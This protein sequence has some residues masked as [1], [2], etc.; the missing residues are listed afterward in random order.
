MYYLL[1]DRIVLDYIG[2]YWIGLYRI[3]SSAATAQVG[4][5]MMRDSDSEEREGEL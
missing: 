2:S 1:F 5:Y 4:E 3:G